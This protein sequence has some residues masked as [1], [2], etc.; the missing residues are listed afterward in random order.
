MPALSFQPSFYSPVNEA[1]VTT[2]K[3]RLN[4]SKVNFSFHILSFKALP[5]SPRGPRSFFTT[6]YTRSLGEEAPPKKDSLFSLP[7]GPAGATWEAVPAPSQCV[8]RAIKGREG[9]VF[10]P[11][12]DCVAILIAH[13]LLQLAVVH[14]QGEGWPESS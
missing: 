8:Q 3:E 5:S 14:R 1:E 7:E 10:M 9:S 11:A 4:E 2:V 13:R 12:G 6:S